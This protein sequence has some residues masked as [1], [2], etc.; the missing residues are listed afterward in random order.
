MH[1][2]IRAFIYSLPCNYLFTCWSS[3]P[4]SS[5]RARSKPYLQFM[6]ASS[7]M[8]SWAGHSKPF[9]RRHRSFLFLAR[10]SSCISA[11]PL[12]LRQIYLCLHCPMRPLLLK[13]G[14]S[15]T[16][17]WFFCFP[18]SYDFIE[19]MINMSALYLPSYVIFKNLLLYTESQPLMTPVICQEIKK[20]CPSRSMRFSKLYTVHYKLCYMRSHGNLI[21]NFEEIIILYE[22]QMFI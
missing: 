21:I 2:L 19:E 22:F 12:S 4:I 5:F 8:A 9:Q 14:L 17:F 11:S 10:C 1:N 13:A 16:Q 20:S 15:F 6:L 18:I 3:L 7:M